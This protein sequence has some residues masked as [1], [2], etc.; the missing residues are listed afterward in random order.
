MRCPLLFS[1]ALLFA[2][3][4]QIAQA[5]EASVEQ[6]DPHTLA[7]ALFPPEEAATIVSLKVNRPIVHGSPIP[8]VVLFSRPQPA[9]SNIC[10]R[11]RYHVSL[12]LNKE[13]VSS[14]TTRWH[15]IAVSASCDAAADK[16]FARVVPIN[17][18]PAEAVEALAWLNA[19]VSSRASLSEKKLSLTCQNRADT[20][21][22]SKNPYQAFSSIKI[23]NVFI[24]EKIGSGSWEFSVHSSKNKPS[25]WVI[26][27]TG[28]GKEITTIKMEKIIPSPF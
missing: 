10:R 3:S 4:P 7:R 8:S 11:E 22:C 1:A 18:P 12:P 25:V 20:E 13:A 26:N 14:W 27:A 15:E 6:F 9:G 21:E 23:E 5:S 28:I 17:L 24:I 2:G 19:A 16:N